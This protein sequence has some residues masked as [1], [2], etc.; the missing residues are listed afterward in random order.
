[1]EY[2]DSR[3]SREHSILEDPS[4]AIIATTLAPQLGSDQRDIDAG[5]TDMRRL[6]V[7]ERDELPFILY[8]KLRARK[9]RAWKLVHDDLLSL[10]VSVGG[11][12]RRDIIRMEQ[13]SKGVPVNVGDEIVEP[14]WIS[15]NLTQRNW[16]RNQREALQ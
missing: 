2:E 10:L 7:I 16:E 1:M 15:R 8:S 13:V 6:T 14:G 5:R 4:S 11:R 3:N 9:S 12:G